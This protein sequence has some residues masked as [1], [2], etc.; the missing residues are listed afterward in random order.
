MAH[1][2]YALL[3][4]L[5]GAF[6]PNINPNPVTMINRTT[7]TTATTG[8]DMS[9]EMRIYYDDQL[10]EMAEPY[11]VHDR[12]AQQK[13]IPRNSGKTIQFRKYDPFPKA[14]TPLTEGVTPDGRK[15]NVTAMESTVA[16]YGDYVMLSDVLDLTAVDNNLNEAQVQLSGQAGRT[17]DTITREV[18]NGGTNVQYGEGSVNGRHL[19][20]GGES[21]GN[22]YLTVRAVRKAARFLKS[23]NAPL[24]NGSYWAIIHPDVAYDIMDD[25]D[26][27]NPHTYKDTAN[28][29]DDEI[30]KIAGVRF[31]ETTEA[32]VFHAENLTAA[33]RNLS[34]KT[35]ISSSTTTVAVN[36][37]ISSAEATALAGRYILIG[38]GKFKIASA[39]AGAANSASLTLASTTPISSAAANAVIYPG[40]AGAKGRDVYST[41]IFG[42]NAYGVTEV[43][44]GGLQFIV[45][46]LGSAGTADP[47]N[48]RSTA[49]WKAI[50]TAERLIEAYMVRVE[51]GSTFNDNK[52]N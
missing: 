36:E 22:N 37:A 48:Q 52:A 42:A 33:A 1:T 30:G 47:L 14:L 39:T 27:K 13:P 51:T 15:L 28:I 35:Q 3:T 45:K 10:I 2:K 7:D 50:K 21:S 46:Q 16:Q 41:M 19:L 20:V 5:I 17:L 34:V 9:A 29:Y 4:A 26:W 32:K 6:D 11:L 12:W 31:V 18:M 43:K 38:S 24:I 8:N 44:G 25:S 40:E 49:G 23:M